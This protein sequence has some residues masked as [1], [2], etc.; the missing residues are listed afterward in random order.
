MG[1]CGF[2]R[3]DE[4]K[5]CLPVTFVVQKEQCQWLPFPPQKGGKR[6]YYTI[7]AELSLHFFVVED[8]AS[9]GVYFQ[10]TAVM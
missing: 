7:T 10:R 8:F 9:V 6:G 3:G 4:T 1:F 5:N 2:C